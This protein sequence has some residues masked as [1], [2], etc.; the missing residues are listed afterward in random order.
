MKFYDVTAWLTDYFYTHI[1]PLSR[2]GNQTMKF[3]QLKE[4]NMKSIFLEKPRTKCG[5]ETSLRLFSEK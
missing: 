2:E 1:A 3:A 5:G 4:C